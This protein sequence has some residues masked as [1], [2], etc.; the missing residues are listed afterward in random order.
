MERNLN[1]KIN[2]INVT[3]NEVIDLKPY[4]DINLKY[5]KQDMNYL[6]KILDLVQQKNMGTKYV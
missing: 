1:G 4:V 6:Q 5:D 2:N 3:P